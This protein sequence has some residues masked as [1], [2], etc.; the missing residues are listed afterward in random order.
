MTTIQEN[1]N[2]SDRYVPNSALLTSNARPGQ[3]ARREGAISIAQN[4]ASRN[5]EVTPLRSLPKRTSSPGHSTRY[6]Y[7]PHKV[8]GY[9]SDMR[10][11]RRN[12][13]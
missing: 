3:Q 5:L 8:S 2:D 12:G 11:N 13:T 9:L 6:D 10:I 7:T 4:P 1:Q